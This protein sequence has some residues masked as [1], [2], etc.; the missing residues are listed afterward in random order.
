MPIQAS[1]PLPCRAESKL[2]LQNVTT[3]FS[4]PVLTKNLFADPQKARDRKQPQP[5]LQEEFC[6]KTF[7]IIFS[8]LPEVC[9][10]LRPSAESRLTDGNTL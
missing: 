6:N 10:C 5:S 7:S 8:S 1:R 2:V 9:P 3:E 4:D